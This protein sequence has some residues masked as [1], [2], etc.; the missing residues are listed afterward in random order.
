MRIYVGIFMSLMV[1]VAHANSDLSAAI[2]N[3]RITCGNISTELTDMKKMAGIATAVTGVG[4]V[5]GGVALGTG[6]AKTNADK[7]IADLEQQLAR[8]DADR[9]LQTI[10]ISATNL[11]NELD[12]YQASIQTLSKSELQ[13]Q[14]SEAEQKSK[15][16]GNIRTG[17]LAVATATNI[18][19]AVMSGT[20]RVKGNLKQQIDECLAS[21][22]TLSNV[23]MQARISK[24]VTDAD[25]ARAE[26]IV[27][28]C[29][30]WSTVEV[31]SINNRSTGATVSAG[32]GAGLGLAGTITSASANSDGVRNGDDKQREKNLNTAANVLAGGTTAAGL[33][34]TIFNAT[35]ISAIKRA[36]TVADE[37]EGALK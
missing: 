10:T 29:D 28:A 3:V 34:A 35:Q 23:R 17:T 13:E 7:E 27:R 18:A 30:A 15:N 11:Q 1:G 12:Q 36:A 37:C 25:L 31:S 24:T 5:A 21:V 4:T 33:S 20:N 19:G 32:I 9:N 8:L 2:E 22:K 14:K 16:L 6:L 26:N